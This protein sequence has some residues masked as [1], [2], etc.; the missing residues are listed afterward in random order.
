VDHLGENINSYIKIETEITVGV[1][2]EE[3][4]GVIGDR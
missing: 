2:K 3:E 4:M 1:G